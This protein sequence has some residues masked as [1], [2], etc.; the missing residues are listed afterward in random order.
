M[1]TLVP[2]ENLASQQ[3]ET[4][5]MTIVLEQDPLVHGAFQD[6]SPALVFCARRRHDRAKM[7]AEIAESEGVTLLLSAKAAP[8]PLAISVLAPWLHGYDVSNAN[9]ILSIFNYSREK[10]ISLTGPICV[11]G[12]ADL[13]SRREAPT[14]LNAETESQLAFACGLGTSGVIPGVRLRSAYS[15][16]AFDGAPPF[17]FDEESLI[18][19][20]VAN[21]PEAQRILAVHVHAGGR[22]NTVEIIL[23]RAAACLDA[24][25]RLGLGISHINYGGGFAGLS[26]AQFRHCL[27]QLA[28]LTDRQIHTLI[29]PGEYFFADCGWAEATVLDVT[30]TQR[31]ARAILDL[32][33]EAHLRWSRVGALVRESVPE[34]E[35]VCRVDFV[36]PTCHRG[37]F[38]G[39]RGIKP[40]L[41][42]PHGVRAGDRVRILGITSYSAA[43]NLSF[44]GISQAGVLVVET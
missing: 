1:C 39:R 13:I 2:A 29:E 24:T 7:L 11:Q 16:A 28:S 35:V 30:P 32:S 27:N 34:E 3:L 37:D 15:P 41:G 33:S 18:K 21:R 38:L 12:T 4:K 31:G 20:L 42:R 23:L 17:G 22:D 19:T 44:N 43:W 5:S 40:S 14:I 8:H 10:T 25:K 6:R 26:L 9:E 36:G